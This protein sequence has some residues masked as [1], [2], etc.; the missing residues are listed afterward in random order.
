M[1]STSE[2]D[3]QE[4]LEINGIEVPGRDHFTDETDWE[5]NFPRDRL[6]CVEFSKNSLTVEIRQ[7]KPMG[8][9]LPFRVH[10]AL[11][12]E[13]PEQIGE[14]DYVS[15]AYKY[16]LLYILGLQESP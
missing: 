8:A 5:V 11:P 4:A 12:D 1:S 15:E 13:K 2:F 10:Q 16:V 9:D 3:I 7:Q 14:A 6:N